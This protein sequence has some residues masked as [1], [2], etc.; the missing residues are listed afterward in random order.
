MKNNE[1]IAVSKAFAAILIV[2]ML[3]ASPAAAASTYKFLHAFRMAQ[4]PRGNLVLDAAGNL[5]G[6]TYEG[7][8]YGYGVVFKL[9]P[10]P[11]GT[12]TERTLYNFGGADGANPV[13]GLIMDAAGN[14]YG[15][16]ARG[17]AFWWGVVFKL[18]PTTHG[19]WTESVLFSF[20]WPVGISPYAPLTFDANGNLYGSTLGGGATGDGTI[21]KLAPNSDGTWTHSV[22][23]HFTHADG[24]GL[25]DALTFDKAG[26]LYGTAWYG[27]TH[28]WGVVFKLTLNSDG[29]TTES[30]LYNF[31]G[32][33]DGSGPFGVVFDAAGNL[34]GMT[35]HGGV[36]CPEV[37]C[38]VVF[39]LTPSPDGSWTESVLHRF[40]GGSDGGGPYTGVI[41]DAA[42]NLYGATMGGGC[43][44]YGVVIELAP[45]SKGWHETILHCFTGYGAYPWSGLTM[46]AAGNL[47][48]TTSSGRG[49]YGTVFEITQ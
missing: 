37:G 39:K 15:T 48:G 5:Y 12:W 6:T 9:T 8:W 23:H 24:G 17:G 46:D 31:Q 28:D 38:G 2:T 27:G 7:G 20:D 3:L 44:G 4:S 34:Y 13:A 21:F 49:N 33:E 41:V 47:Y 25:Y 45:T 26:N 16:A 10:N 42:G 36:G 11:D 22:L 18:A 14:L 35:L 19:A 1:W 30:T 43:A 29:T 32:G 40:T